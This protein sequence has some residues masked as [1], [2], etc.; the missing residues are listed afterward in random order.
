MHSYPKLIGMNHSTETD[1]TVCVVPE[2]NRFMVH[3]ADIK[4]NERT[5]TGPERSDRI[6]FYAHCP[7]LY[8]KRLTKQSHDLTPYNGVAE[9]HAVDEGHE[10]RNCKAAP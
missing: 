3:P 10:H 9:A 7:W 6:G 8:P 4:I 5:R 2:N 1:M